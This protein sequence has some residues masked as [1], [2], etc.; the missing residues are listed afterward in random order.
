MPFYK[1]RRSLDSSPG[2]VYNHKEHLEQHSP[3]LLECSLKWTSVILG[4]GP[5]RL[6][7][8]LTRDGETEG[9]K[10]EKVQRDE[11]RGRRGGGE[12]MNLEELLP[13]RP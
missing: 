3:A 8:G 9:G 11:V 5:H 7:P 2:G 10:G 6:L 1:R 12:E 13:T 4:P